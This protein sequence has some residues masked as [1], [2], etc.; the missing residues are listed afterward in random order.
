M[1][2]ERGRTPVRVLDDLYDALALGTKDYFSKTG[3]FERF[4]V[5]LSGGR[6]SL[7]TLLIAWRAVQMLTEHEPGDDLRTSTGRLIQAFYMPSRYSTDGTRNAAAVICDEIGVDLRTLAIDDAFDRELS[8]TREIPG[9]R[10][11][12]EPTAT[13]PIFD[14]T[15]TGG[16]RKCE[17]W[18]RRNRHVPRKRRSSQALA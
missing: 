6:D 1:S 16:L 14:P 10:L 8:A 17:L 5:A 9:K 3:C 11:L 13:A 15:D 18:C 7:L 2:A 12:P 4:G